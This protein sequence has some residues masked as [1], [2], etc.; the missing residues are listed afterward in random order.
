MG[1]SARR[2]RR[3]RARRPRVRESESACSMLLCWGLA[4]WVPARLVG[5][6]KMLAGKL[7][8]K[9]EADCDADEHAEA[10]LLGYE[11]ADRGRAIAL[12]GLAHCAAYR[13]VVD[14]A[15]PAPFGE[16]LG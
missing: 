9:L 8:G 5:L 15:E 14:L 11:R 13:G 2:C 12:L 3:L 16:R 10:G 1:R 7:V 4:C 6:G